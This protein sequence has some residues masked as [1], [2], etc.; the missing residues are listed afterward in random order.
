MSRAELRQ[1]LQSV[2]LQMGRVM[3]ANDRGELTESD[4]RYA[5]DRLDGVRLV[6]L[7]LLKEYEVEE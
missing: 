6:V 4:H 7:D 2:E 5:L 1:V 3:D